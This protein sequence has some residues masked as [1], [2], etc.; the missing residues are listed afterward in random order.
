[1][2]LTLKTFF[3]KKFFSPFRL[4]SLII[5]PFVFLILFQYIRL[6]HLEI[7]QIETLPSTWLPG[8]KTAFIQTPHGK[9]EY[10]IKYENFWATSYNHTCEGCDMIT[11]TGMLQSYG[12]VAV[13]PKVIPLFTKMYIPGY[14][15]AIAGD[16]GGAIKGRRI[17]LGFTELDGSFSSGPVDV[18]IL[19]N[20][21]DLAITRLQPSLA[22]G[23]RQG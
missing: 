18:Y 11:A 23:V 4:V 5:T 3:H 19:V 9:L 20:A 10:S 22:R 7:N 16:V 17:D 6:F 2:K 21:D 12:V 15:I 8:H 13:D 14:G 1:M